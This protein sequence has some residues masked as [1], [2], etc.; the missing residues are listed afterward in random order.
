MAKRGRPRKY[1]DVETMRAKIDA[2]FDRCA[3][4]EKPL[5][6][7]GLARALGMTRQGLLDYE[8]RGDFADTIKDAKAAV[9]E[10]LETKLFG[11]AVAGVIFNLKNNF[12]WKDKQEH[13]LSGSM[14]MTVVTGVPRAPDEPTNG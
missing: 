5:T 4:E 3:K 7:T 9:E 2:Y 6:V 10:F 1:T 8:E 11:Q 14:T 13:D 12:K